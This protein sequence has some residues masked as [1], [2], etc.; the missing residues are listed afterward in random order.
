MFMTRSISSLPLSKH[1]FL[2]PPVLH[3]LPHDAL[4]PDFCILPNRVAHPHRISDLPV[5]LASPHAE[6]TDQTHLDKTQA[7]YNTSV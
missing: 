3:T 4:Y 5:Y 2:C 7:T 1:S 6:S